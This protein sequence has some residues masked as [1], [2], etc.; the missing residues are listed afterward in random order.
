MINITPLSL[1]THQG[2]FLCRAW[3]VA[4]WEGE[5]VAFGVVGVQELGWKIP[6]EAR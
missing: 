4:W 2:E 3:K 5:G 1:L 6:P